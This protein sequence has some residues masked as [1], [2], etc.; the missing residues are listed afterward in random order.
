[1]RSLTITEEAKHGQIARESAGAP[2]DPSH[3]GLLLGQ[4]EDAVHSL[5]EQAAFQRL[6]VV[7]CDSLERVEFLLGRLFISI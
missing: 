2:E 3:V 5:G 4:L 1:M 7:R 6:R